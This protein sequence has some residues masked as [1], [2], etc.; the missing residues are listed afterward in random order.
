MSWV[1]R[2]DERI[3]QAS[4]FR[5]E[6]LRGPIPQG[7][8]PYLDQNADLLNR[9]FGV[10][11]LLVGIAVLLLVAATGYY[12]QYSGAL[13]W[14]LFAIVIGAAG[15]LAVRALGGS[16]RDPAR[17]A[18]PRTTPP[19]GGE[20]SALRMTM[21][22]ANDGLA[23][24]Q[25]IAEDRIREAF[26]EKVRVGRDVPQDGIHAAVRDPRRHASLIGD[27]ELAAFVYES[28]Q[29]ARRYPAGLSKPPKG[30]AFARRTSR[31]LDRMEAWR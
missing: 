23:Y 27:A 3:A 1:S 20:L 21:V 8:S 24:S 5:R 12:A 31:L 2:E 6:V 15:L 17:F 19:I 14:I 28:A 29:N 25:V 13:R 4:R 18:A 7:G 16:I 9:A 26:L 11:A 30:E 22:R 10:T